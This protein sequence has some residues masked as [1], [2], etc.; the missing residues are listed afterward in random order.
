MNELDFYFII[1]KRYGLSNLDMADLFGVRVSTI[2]KWISGQSSPKDMYGELI[3]IEEEIEW[4]I[5]YLKQHKELDDFCAAHFKAAKYA[6][7]DKLEGKIKMLDT[8]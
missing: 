5:S 4:V 6:L 8:N 3:Q 7:M 2:E 1:K